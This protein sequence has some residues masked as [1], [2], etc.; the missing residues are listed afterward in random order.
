VDIDPEIL[1]QIDFFPNDFE[2]PLN[3]VLKLKGPL[4][5]YLSIVA[6][7][8]LREYGV[9]LVHFP[10]DIL[11][12]AI[13]IYPA[14]SSSGPLNKRRMIGYE[15]YTQIKMGLMLPFGEPDYYNENSRYITNYDAANI[16]WVLASLVPQLALKL[17]KIPT[18]A[19]IVVGLRDRG[20][21]I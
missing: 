19:A 3:G 11:V 5:F 21:K 1:A 14:S 16:R 20:G 12:S 8:F 13:P 7:S 18:P 15:E 2:I 9:G 10:S 17:S 6:G 4:T